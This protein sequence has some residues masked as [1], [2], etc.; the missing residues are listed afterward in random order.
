MCI[1]LAFG[2]AQLILVLIV[3]FISLS[4]L[5]ELMKEKL[6]QQYI[7]LITRPRA[8]SFFRENNVLWISSSVTSICNLL[9]FASETWSENNVVVLLIMMDSF[10]LDYDPE[11]M[12]IINH[13]LPQMRVIIYPPICNQAGSM[14]FGIKTKI[15]SVV[16]NI[17]IYT[18]IYI[19]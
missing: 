15:L 3:E 1:I 17:N 16:L 2:I 12:I 7:V 9:L 19:Y 6:P 18:Y 10:R 5:P 13:H 8:L 4:N 11:S 14:N